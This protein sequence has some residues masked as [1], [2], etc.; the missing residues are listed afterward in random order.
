MKNIAYAG[1]IVSVLGI[2]VDMVE[3][4]IA[5]KY[6]G[7]RS[8]STPIIRRF[9][10]ATISRRHI[11]SPIVSAGDDGGDARANSDRREYRVRSGAVYAGATVAAWYPITPSTSVMDAFQAFCKR[12][13]KDPETGK[14]N[15]LILQAEDE[16]AAIG[17]V[18]GANGMALE[19]LRR[20]P[21][22][23]FP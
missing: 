9:I 19:H 18:I 22:P 4:L 5:K 10:S 3:E 2:D 8:C 16:L 12:Y 23:E 11:S 20:H 15:Y 6:V 13:R 1:A 7:K 17:M 21:D 14:N